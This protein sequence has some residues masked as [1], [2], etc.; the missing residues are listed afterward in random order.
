[1]EALDSNELYKKYGKYVGKVSSRTSVE[2]GWGL[3]VGEAEQIAWEAALKCYGQYV[4]VNAGGEPVS[5]EAY[6]YKRI[7][8][9]I[10][11]EVRKRT[12]HRL[13][14]G[15]GQ[16]VFV[17]KS[18]VHMADLTDTEYSE[19]TAVPIDPE[20][21]FKPSF[22]QIVSPLTN[23]R[24]VNILRLLYVYELTMAEV[25]MI[26]GVSEARIWQIDK[27]TTTKLRKHGEIYGTAY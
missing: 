2:F 15:E 20:D 18:M 25:S 5:F 14:D 24:D 22:D 3:D 7:R 26:Y 8:G 6:S 10:I 16:R 27:E 1:M 23:E 12:A 9:S 21:Y 11:D 13:N 4:G 19:I 17:S